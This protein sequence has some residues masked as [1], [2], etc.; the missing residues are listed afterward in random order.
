MIRYRTSDD[1]PHIYVEGRGII[2]EAE[3]LANLDTLPD[4]LDAAPSGFVLL[5]EYPGLLRIEDAAVGRLFYY[6]ARVFEAH[7]GLAVFVT[8]GGSG[9]RKRGPSSSVRLEEGFGARPVQREFPRK[10]LRV[11]NEPPRRSVCTYR[12]LLGAGNPPCLAAGSVPLHP[13]SA[14]S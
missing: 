14:M 5:A 11:P 7:P 13:T 2:T 1:A 4:A 9:I 10:L 3:V 6:I 12:G 8:G